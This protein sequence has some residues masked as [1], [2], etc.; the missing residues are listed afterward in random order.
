PIRNNYR[1]IRSTFQSRKT[2]T[3][4]IIYKEGYLLKKFIHTMLIAILVFSSLPLESI[5]ATESDTSETEEVTL[6]LPNTNEALTIYQDEALT[7][8][9]TN[10]KNKSDAILL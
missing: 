2:K 10:I 4:N 6:Y 3:L 9:L 5:F 1:F 8:V 7:E